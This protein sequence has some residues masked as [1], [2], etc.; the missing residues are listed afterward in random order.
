MKNGDFMSNLV[1]E[2]QQELLQKDCDIVNALRKAHVI[3]SKLDLKEF[4]EWIQYELNGYS[5]HLDLIPSYRKVSGDVKGKNAFGVWVPVIGENGMRDEELS[6]RPLSQD[7]PTLINLYETSGKNEIYFCFSRDMILSV[8]DARV[9]GYPSDMALFI[10]SSQLKNIV[11][12]VKNKLLEWLIQI[13]KTEVSMPDA[14]AKSVTN[15]YVHGDINS[16]N[17]AT[18]NSVAPE[19]NEAPDEQKSFFEKY[20]FPLLLAL[21]GVVGAIIAALLQ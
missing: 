2:L 3:A 10:Q 4:D 19:Y 8:I 16:S 5:G 9:M 1:L 21:I 6:I 15:I 18:G 7:L 20:G 13:E 17:I 14:P 11:E 12:S